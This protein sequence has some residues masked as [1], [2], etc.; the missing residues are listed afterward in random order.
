MTRARRVD[1]NQSEIVQALRAVGASVHITSRF[2]EG[3]PDLVVGFGG[4]TFLLEVKT[5]D[6]KLTEDE[7]EFFDNWRGQVALV[8]DAS[9]A[10]MIVRGER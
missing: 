3:F 8:R 2:G 1:R 7:R 9:D 5:P 4:V 10:V 6:G